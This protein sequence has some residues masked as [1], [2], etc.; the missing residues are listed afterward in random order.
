ME[1][2]PKH[3]GKEKEKVSNSGDVVIVINSSDK[4][5]LDLGCSYHILI[6]IGFLHP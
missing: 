3:K 6:G 4:W 2:C 5:I 1:N